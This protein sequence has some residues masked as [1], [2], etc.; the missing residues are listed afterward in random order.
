MLQVNQ[1]VATKYHSSTNNNETTAKRKSVCVEEESL[2][3]ALFAAQVSGQGYVWTFF[4]ATLNTV[5]NVSLKAPVRSFE[6][7]SFLIG[8]IFIIKGKPSKSMILG[9]CALKDVFVQI[10]TLWDKCCH[11]DLRYWSWTTS[12]SANRPHH[13]AHPM[14]V[15]L[16]IWVLYF[17]SSLYVTKGGV[18]KGGT[19]K[20]EEGF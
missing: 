4:V 16:G 8:F 2:E 9:H 18:F 13:L 7:L 20:T 6:D 5:W 11:L 17:L 12:S 3:D 19:L 10:F 1:A 15:C 14:A